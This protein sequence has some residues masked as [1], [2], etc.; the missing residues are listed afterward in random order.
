MSHIAVLVIGSI[1][2]GASVLL[3]LW[4]PFKKRLVDFNDLLR[5][6]ISL[7]ATIGGIFLGVVSFFQTLGFV[8]I[9]V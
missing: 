9:F 5:V 3:V 4:N 8:F 7:F 2:V 6:T 1:F